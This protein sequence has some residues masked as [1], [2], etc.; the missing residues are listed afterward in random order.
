MTLRKLMLPTVLVAGLLLTSCSASGSPAESPAPQQGT[1]TES[2]VEEST[3]DAQPSVSTERDIVADPP[4]HSPEEALDAAKKIFTGELSEI[5]LKF[6]RS[7]DPVYRI[8]LFSDTEEADIDL[9]AETLEEVQREIESREADDHFVAI[10]LGALLSLDEAAE[11]ARAE[12]AGAIVEWEL[13]TDDQVFEY[14]F[15]FVDGSDDVEVVVNAKT[16]EI[17]EIDR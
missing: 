13:D 4:A 11:L 8:E 9:N 17:I 7:G 1:T 3:A 5:K 15:K 12:T 6:A 16:G 10:D 14:E 2:T